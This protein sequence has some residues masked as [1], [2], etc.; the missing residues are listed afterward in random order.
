MSCVCAA[1]FCG[2]SHFVPACMY[3][4]FRLL[5]THPPP[6]L[7]LQETPAISKT[8]TRLRL[9]VPAMGVLELSEVAVLLV[10][11]GLGVEV[12]EFFND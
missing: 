2:I 11:R 5:D 7:L 6:F 1:F 3:I 8:V 12:V 9:V 4:L 10:W